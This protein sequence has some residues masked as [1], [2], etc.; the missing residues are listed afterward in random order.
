MKNAD[1][2]I[3]ANFKSKTHLENSTY[4]WIVKAVK[5]VQLRI[6]IQLVKN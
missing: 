1:L 6:R 5:K 2:V 3:A 4:K